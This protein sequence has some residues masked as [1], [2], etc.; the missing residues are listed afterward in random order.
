M[1]IV[2]QWSVSAEPITKPV[3]DTTGYLHKNPENKSIFIPM[4]IL[5][6]GM[7]LRQGPDIIDTE[8]LTRYA[9][10]LT[11]SKVPYII[12]IECW[13]VRP[14]VSDVE[15][16]ANIDKLILVIKT[17]KEAR[18]D[19]MFGY[20]GE[21]PTRD[22][23]SPKPAVGIK[24]Q[25]WHNSNVRLKRLA[26]YVDV[27]CPDLYTHFDDVESWKQYA[28]AA[29]Q[30]ARMYGK[31]IYPFIWMEFHDAHEDLKGKYIDS[32]FW[33]QQLLHLNK[34]A[35]GIIIW[36]GRDVTVKPHTSKEWN[37]NDPWWIT[38]KDFILH[39][40]QTPISTTK[41]AIEKKN[42]PKPPTKA[43]PLPKQ[44]SIYLPMSQ[45]VP[46]PVKSPKPQFK[47]IEIIKE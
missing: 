9:K 36:G 29:I 21:L 30:E 15:A 22:Y 31:P 27:I 16:D 35:D 39:N 19:L 25:K 32:A 43:K 42:L 18:P 37:E 1:F 12:D 5:Y 14:N 17:L 4:Q 41:A 45:S 46:D 11:N 23:V 47:K 26:K 28:T 24:Y 20:Y 13:N 40:Q 38:T 2:L 6:Q 33:E 3:F 44:Q 8:F 10:K 7:L 34:I